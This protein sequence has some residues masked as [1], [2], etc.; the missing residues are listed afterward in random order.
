MPDKRQ[1]QVNSQDDSR[2]KGTGG[3]GRANGVGRCQGG[4][5]R[6][7]GGRGRCQTG[8]GQGRNAG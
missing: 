8:N 5:G 3:G 7:R 1:N 2:R 6:G 4:T